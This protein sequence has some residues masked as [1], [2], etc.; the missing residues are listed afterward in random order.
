MGVL[1]GRDRMTHGG[2]VSLTL[3]RRGHARSRDGLAGGLVDLLELVVGP[4]SADH[5]SWMRDGL[6]IVRQ[7]LTVRYCRP[8]ALLAR[9]RAERP[10]LACPA[11]VARDAQ[12]KLHGR[13]G[14]TV[15]QAEVQ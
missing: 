4:L 14:G 11:C 5:G 3:W 8:R 15:A 12:E 13:S 10:A 1:K 6:L 7:L 2:I 9:A